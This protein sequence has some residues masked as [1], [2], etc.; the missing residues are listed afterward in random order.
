MTDKEKLD[1][2]SFEL[3]AIQNET[4]RGEVK[5]LLL[6]TPE[7][8]WQIPASSTGKYHPKFSL[9]D[10]GLIRHTKVAC[11]FAI[12]MFNLE[13][14]NTI[15]Q[16][17]RDLIIGALILHD[18]CKTG[19]EKYT[20]FDH[21]IL[22]AKFIED[23]CISIDIAFKLCELIKTHMGQWNTDTRTNQT[24]PKPQT[25]QQKFVHLCD[26]LSSRKEI[27]FTF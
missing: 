15:V 6:R 18:C 4:I 12:Q 23:N 17:D 13:M 7:Y 2:F 9:G 26:Y 25:A 5:H 27:E 20:R 22:A 16:N 14:W 11:Y 21:P 19:G 8:F 3:S 10:G 24:L 1:L